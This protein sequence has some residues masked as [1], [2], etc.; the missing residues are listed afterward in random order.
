M[1]EIKVHA[2]FVR[3]SPRKAQLVVN[4]VRGTKLEKA[5]AELRFLNKYAA[6]PVFHLLKSGLVAANDKE[7]D[8]K[9]LFIKE[10]Y[11]N[12]GPR[13]KRRMI[14]ERGKASAI[15]KRMS[16]F[17]LVLSDVKA[18]NKKNK[19]KI[20]A[21]KEKENSKVKTAESNKNI[22]L[23]KSAVSKSNKA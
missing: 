2:K 23:E 3:I 10:I 11:C 6:K 8:E 21:V 7:L 9:N 22:K 13:L 17:T 16:H 14:K 4:L 15:N 5:L 12:E 1:P 19:E 20:L 18:K